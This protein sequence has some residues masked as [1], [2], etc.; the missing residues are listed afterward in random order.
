MNAPIYIEGDDEPGNVPTPPEHRAAARQALEL[1]L[2]GWTDAVDKADVSDRYRQVVAETVERVRDAAEYGTTPHNLV[3]TLFAV[4]FLLPDEPH[5]AS[6]MSADLEAL[7]I[8]LDRG[9][10]PTRLYP[11]LFDDLEDAA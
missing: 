5:P 11:S 8:V 6:I 9:D 7:G 3:S 4:A 2:G 1:L 10:N